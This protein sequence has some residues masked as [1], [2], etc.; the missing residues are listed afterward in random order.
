MGDNLVL[1]TPKEGE[2]M[3]DLIK[4]NKEWFDNVFEVIEP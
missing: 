3:E 1:L 2:R 4:L